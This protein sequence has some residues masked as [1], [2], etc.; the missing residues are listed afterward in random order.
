MKPIML[1]GRQRREMREGTDLRDW[2]PPK[3]G[4]GGG[5]KNHDHFFQSRYRN[6]PDL[7]THGFMAGALAFIGAILSRGRR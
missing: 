6:E 2:K 5:R 4:R 3:G 7:N 1:T